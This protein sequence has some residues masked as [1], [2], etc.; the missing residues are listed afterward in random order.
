MIRFSALPGPNTLAR[1]RRRADKRGSQAQ[2][3]G[4]DYSLL[5]GTGGS[6]AHLGA[7]WFIFWQTLGN[8]WSLMED[9][10]GEPLVSKGG[11]RGLEP[12]LRDFDAPRLSKVDFQR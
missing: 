1:P 8:L 2:G 6:G 9:Q 10:A 11:P 7:S 3:T 12:Q 5:P 4:D